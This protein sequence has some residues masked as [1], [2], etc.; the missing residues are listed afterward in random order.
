MQ[1]CG[2]V[3]DLLGLRKGMTSASHHVVGKSLFIQI[4]A[5]IDSR[6]VKEN[7]GK[8]CKGCEYHQAI[9]ARFEN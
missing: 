1:V 4:L 9:T 7:S 2:R 8:C 3:T 6:R 5:N